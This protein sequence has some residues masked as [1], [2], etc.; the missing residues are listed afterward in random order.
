M[1]RIYFV[2]FRFPDVSYSI[3]LLVSSTNYSINTRVTFIKLYNLNYRI[4]F[5]FLL[6][7][8]RGI[9]FTGFHCFYCA[10]TRETLSPTNFVAVF[11]VTKQCVCCIPYFYYRERYLFDATFNT[12]CFRIEF[13]Y[14][15]TFFICEPLDDSALQCRV[16][17]V[18]RLFSLFVLFCFSYFNSV[19]IYFNQ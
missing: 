10:S 11:L 14:F 19:Y 1:F 13:Y 7:W 9:I 5:P 6:I 3:S 17:S 18:F 12:Y 8:T 4:P 16:C 15:V 2:F